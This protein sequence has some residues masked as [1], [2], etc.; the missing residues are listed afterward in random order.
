MKK[1]VRKVPNCH[2]WVLGSSTCFCNPGSMLPK[3]GSGPQPNTRNSVSAISQ[4]LLTQFGPN[5]KV[6]FLGPSLTDVKY[7]GDICPCNICSRDICPYLQY[8]SCYL[9]NFDQT[10]KVGFWGHLYR[11]LYVRVKFFQTKFV[12]VN[13]PICTKL[14]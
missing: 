13:D 2:N 9:T 11:M 8:L 10:S 3:N 4:L 5:L 1:R 14:F 12:I 6:T 7:H